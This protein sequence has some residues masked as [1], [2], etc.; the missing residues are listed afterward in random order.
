MVSEILNEGETASNVKIILLKNLSNLDSKSLCFFKEAILNC[1]LHGQALRRDIKI[2]MQTMEFLSMEKNENFQN[3]NS[4]NEIR[5]RGIILL[6]RAICV[7]ENFV[8]EFFH[9]LMKNLMRF[10]G[11]RYFADSNSHRIQQRIFQCLLIMEP[12]L[13]LVNN[14][15]FSL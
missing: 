11:K 9:S 7:D 15:V 6:H 12:I 8:T 13:N 5:A 4:D 10:K 14:F 3:Y 1:L 2:E